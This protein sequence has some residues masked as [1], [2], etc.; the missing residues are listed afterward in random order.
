[1]LDIGATNLELVRSIFAAL[2]RRD[3]SAEWAHPEIE[4]V[5]ID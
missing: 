5:I 4:V 1:V 3:N 2:E